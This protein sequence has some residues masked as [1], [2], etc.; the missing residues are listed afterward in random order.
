MSYSDVVATIALLFR[1]SA[2]LPAV[3]SAITMLSRGKSGKNLTLLQT[4]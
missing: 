3:T 4:E 2:L 1:L